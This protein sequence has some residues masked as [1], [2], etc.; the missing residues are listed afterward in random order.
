M[1]DGSVAVKNLAVALLT[2]TLPLD[3]GRWRSA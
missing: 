3:E 1:R 2:I